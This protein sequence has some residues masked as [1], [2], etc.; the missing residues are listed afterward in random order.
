MNGRALWILFRELAKKRLRILRRYPLN[1][2][3][4]FVY[5]LLFFLLLFF[6]G[7]A[8]AGPELG[9][10]LDGLIVGYFLWTMTISAF[11]SLAAGYTSEAQWGTLE[12]LYMTPFGFTTVSMV[13][14]AVYML[15]TLLWGAGILAVML[16]VS[17]HA[18]HVDLVTI[19]PLTLLTLAPVVGFGVVIGGL[20]VLHKRLAS[21]F[22]VLQFLFI[23]LIAA[24]IT[25]YPWLVYFPVTDGSYMLR[26]SMSEGIRLWEHPPVDLAILVAKAVVFLVIGL[27]LFSNIIE[28][29]RERGVISHH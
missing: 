29:T 5:V 19:L 25:E 26:R 28:T 27:V 11:R 18:V 14:I 22:N 3:G 1:T 12:Q 21:V 16:A 24:P 8:V 4:Q 23:G 10:N 2:A 9:G 13:M 20:A 6:G 7:R 17:G 15:E